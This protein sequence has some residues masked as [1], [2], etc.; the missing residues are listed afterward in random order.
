[1][2]KCGENKHGESN[3][4]VPFNMCIELD[5]E[6]YGIYPIFGKMCKGYEGEMLVQL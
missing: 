5:W 6:F 2:E 4:H 3:M 1:M